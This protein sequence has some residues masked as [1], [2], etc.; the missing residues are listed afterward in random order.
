[1]TTGK[2][3]PGP[4]RQG[5]ALS[6]AVT[7]GWSHEVREQVQE[8]E[9]V[10]VFS[11]FNAADEGRGRRL[12]AI[13]RRPKDA[14]LGA[15]A[16][17]LLDAVLVALPYVEDALDSPIFKKGVVKKAVAQLRAAIEKAEGKTDA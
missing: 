6:T 12:V 16:P 14:T 9:K 5:K 13:F 11:N 7:R 10:C 17:E 4:W 3:T 1:M 8:H 15:A 2:T